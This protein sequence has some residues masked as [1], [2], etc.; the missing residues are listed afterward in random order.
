MRIKK[1]YVKYLKLKAKVNRF[2][3]RH[4]KNSNEKTK[5]K[6]KRLIPQ[7]PGKCVPGDIVQ[8]DV[9]ERIEEFLKMPSFANFKHRW[10]D[11]P[12]EPSR[13]QI[14]NYFIEKRKR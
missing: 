2:I 9:N 1:M 6:L 14:K 10:N 8:P 11:Q 13:E 3:I 4:L 5:H 12:W 7:K